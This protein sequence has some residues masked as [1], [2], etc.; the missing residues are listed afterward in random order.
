MNRF[1]IFSSLYFLKLVKRSSNYL[2]QRNKTWT[3]QSFDSWLLLHI[4]A[5]KVVQIQKTKA[6]DLV[7]K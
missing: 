7:L 5:H 3:E 6:H 2:A 4:K 1:A